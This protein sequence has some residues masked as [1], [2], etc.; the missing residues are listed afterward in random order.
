MHDN[1]LSNFSLQMIVPIDPDALQCIT[2]YFH[3][4]CSFV[5]CELSMFD[6]LVGIHRSD[7]SN[8]HQC[9]TMHYPISPLQTIVR[10]DPNALQ[11]IIG[12]FHW[13]CSLCRCELSMFDFLVG[14]HRSD[15]SN[16][17][18]CMTMHYPI[19]PSR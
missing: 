11:C 1:A 3:W 5:R 8:D 18:Q 4:L 6:F 16:D 12:Y 2:G 17:H 9:M 19:F 15:H 10:N 14:I 13:H 7:H